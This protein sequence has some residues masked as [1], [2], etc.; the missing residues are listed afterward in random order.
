MPSEPTAAELAASF[1]RRAF[2]AERLTDEGN[3]LYRVGSLSQASLDALFNAAFLSLHSQ[4][5]LFLEDLFFSTVT[6]SSGISDC[7][8]HAVLDTRDKAR[9]VYFPRQTYLT[10]LPFSENARQISKRVYA[11]GSPFDRLTR[12]SDELRVLSSFTKLRNAIAHQSRHALKEVE[13]FT[14][15]LRPR[16]RIVSEYLQVTTQS[17]T[18]FSD[19]CTRIRAIAA[20]L[21]APDT[22]SAKIILT[23]E[24]PYRQ[25]ESPGRGRYRC[26]ICGHSR[27]IRSNQEKLPRCAQCKRREIRQKSNWQRIY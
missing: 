17:R 11:S 21:S 5:E 24:D 1:N 23:P 2:K 3:K 9:L 10:W 8:P 20:A 12:Q 27:N 6:G 4:F 18:Q 13:P 26:V 14:Q 15:P 19:Y 22:P 25:D 16:R 7:A